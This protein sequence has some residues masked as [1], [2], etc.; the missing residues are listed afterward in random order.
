VGFWSSGFVGARLGAPYAPADT[1]LAWRYLVVATLLGAAL[2][3]RGHRPTRAAWRREG[4]LGLLCQSGYLG[5]VVTG[6]T[7]GVPAGTAALVAAL[8]P[9]VVAGLS[10]PVLGEVVRARQWWALGGGLAG[11]ALVM[12][13]DLGSASP[14]ASTAPAWAYALPVAGMLSL[15]LGSVLGERW[16]P[17]PACWSR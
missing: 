4:V 16:R 17:A 12:R 7:L 15:S 9:L 2:W 6:V 14:T 8:Q 11:V 5:G 1:L 10:A 3:W 13:A